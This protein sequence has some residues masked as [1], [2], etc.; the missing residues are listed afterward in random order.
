[1]QAGVGAQK[2]GRVRVAELERYG[3]SACQVRNPDFF[4]QAAGGFRAE[5]QLSSRGKLRLVA[6][7]ETLEQ[8]SEAMVL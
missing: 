7:V 4:L 6:N 5:G 2:T 3:G 8:M 1:M